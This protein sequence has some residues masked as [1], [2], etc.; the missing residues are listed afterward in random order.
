MAT[1]L[2][3]QAQHQG[4]RSHRA[5]LAAGE[6]LDAFLSREQ[7]VEIAGN[8]DAVGAAMA[9]GGAIVARA[10]PLAIACSDQPEYFVR[11]GFADAHAAY[12]GAAVGIAVDRELSYGGKPGRIFLDGWVDIAD[13]IA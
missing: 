9:P 1:R 6:S 5:A 13:E 11:L 3:D 4:P 10:L 2:V 12:S 8:I 7:L